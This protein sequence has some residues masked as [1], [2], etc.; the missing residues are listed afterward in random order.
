MIE[1]SLVRE[2]IQVS[3]SHTSRTRTL[4]PPS[5]KQR[6]LESREGKQ[7]DHMP[8]SQAHRSS[9]ASQ[10]AFDRWIETS[11]TLPFALK[12]SRKRMTY[13]RNLY[14]WMNSF[15]Q[16]LSSRLSIMVLSAAS[17]CRSFSGAMPR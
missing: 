16:E 12:K 7:E 3:L 5:V 9:K 15:L 4:T 13:R 6:Y 11:E 8:H 2:G 10:S 1:G 17:L 14:R